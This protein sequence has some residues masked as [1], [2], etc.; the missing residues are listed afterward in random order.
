MG[1]L[2]LVVAALFPPWKGWG[3]FLGQESHYGFLFSSSRAGALDPTRLFVEW[4]LIAL[5][6]AGL[7]LV[8]RESTFS[9][10]ENKFDT[11]SAKPRNRRLLITNISLV[12]LVPCLVLVSYFAIRKVK[13][14]EAELPPR[15]PVGK[16]TPVP[17]RFIPAP[18]CPTGVPYGVTVEQLSAGEIAK[19]AG[20]NAKLNGGI[21]NYGIINGSTKCLTAV[22][23]AFELQTNSGQPVVKHT[24]QQVDGLSPTW[25]QDGY[26]FNTDRGEDWVLVNWKIIKAWGYDLRPLP[27]PPEGAV[28]IQKPK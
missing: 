11:A 19:L 14:M 10:E 16:L 26:S 2:L 3:Y 18:P 12:V 9:G 23:V 25:Y 28:P 1:F 21:L 15:E 4:A 7:F 5:V 17:P 24:V 20:M 8:F 22:E 13:R 27:P 6:M